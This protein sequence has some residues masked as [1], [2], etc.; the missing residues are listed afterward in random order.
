[1]MR[2][3][4]RF[5]LAA[6]ACALLVAPALAQNPTGTLAGRVTDGSQ[7][8]PGVAVTL[9]SPSLQGTRS[10]VT[11]VGG[12]YI[13]K[14]LPPGDYKVTFALEGFQT[15][16]TNV[17]ITAAQKLPLDAVM[18]LAQV[19][20]ELVVVGSQET[21]STTHQSA[22]TYD[23]DLIQ[24]L[25]VATRTIAG[26]VNLAPGVTNNGPRNGITVSGSQS[27]ENLFLVNGVVV[28]ENLRGQ[29]M[30]LY[31][32]DAVEETTTSLSGVS[33]EY[34]R[35][36][37]GVI[38]TLTKSGGNDFHGSLRDNLAN[39]SWRAPTPLT[40][41]RENKINHTYEATFGGYVLRDRLWFFTAGR[42]FTWDRV[43]Q[44][45]NLLPY[46]YSQKDTRYEGKLTF[47]PV[48]AHR[49]IGSYM[50]RLTKEKNYSFRTTPAEMSTVDPSR[51][52]PYSLLAV[53][54][55]G[56]L[57]DNLFLEGQYSKRTYSFVG[58]GGDAAPGDRVYGT[59][60][61]YWFGT[62]YDAGSPAFCGTCGDEN[63]DNENIVV[64]GSYFHSTDTLGSHDVVF[65]YD[66]FNDMRYNN[67]YQSPSNFHIFLYE[68]DPSYGPNGQL[69]PMIFGYVEMDYW[70]I[71][72][73]SQGTN[74]RTNSL[75]VNDT[76]RIS[77][78]LTANL[79]IR[80]DSNDGK[81]S[82]GKVVASDSRVSPRLGL[83]W[84]V[85]DGWL[86]QGSFGRYVNAVANN[87]AD[88]AG[89][90]VP[91]WFGYQYMG[92]PINAQCDE[93]GANCTFV[94]QYT[95][96]ETIAKM[97][98]WFDSVGGLANTS[99]WYDAPSIRG[100]NEV[101]ENLRSPYADEYTVGLTTKLGDRGMV[102]ADLVHRT[103][104]DFYATR[105]DLTTG[106]VD[107]TVDLAPGVQITQAFD[108]GYVVNE[109]KL[110]SRTYDGLHL[111]FA[112]R[113]TDRF[114]LGGNYTLSRT[115]GNWDGENS[116]SG[117]ITSAI[118][119]YPEYL[120]VRWYAPEGDLSTD[121]RHKLRL[122]AVWTLLSSKRHSLTASLMQNMNTGTPYGALITNVRVS[123]YVT[124]PGY[125]T[126][127]TTNT[128]YFTAR[129]AYRTDT[130][131]STNLS[132]N[133]SF[134]VPLGGNSIEVFVLPEMLNVFN[135]RGV[136]S[137][138]TTV[139]RRSTF[140]PFTDTPTEC[141]QGQADC[142][143]FNWQKGPNFGHAT[144]KES[145][146]QPRTFRISVGVRF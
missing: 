49:L 6:L 4:N 81:D 59:N 48:P 74:F 120:D 2:S 47:S 93:N 92:P 44:T 55:T 144:A 25:P 9:T 116:G 77:D 82:V 118:L 70:P 29:A 3:V 66:T 36:S 85:A 128:Y 1:M 56:A 115:H 112:Y 125:L 24:Q 143:G 91:S 67:N 130:I 97:F 139:F 17:K 102:R 96:F 146:Q 110:L 15:V 107:A 11:E 103:F 38:N 98:E 60:I 132:F 28:N 10:V 63:R 45:Y 65:G 41:S 21:L 104:G 54:Y 53:N 16:D 136:W 109:D 126:P 30:D 108:K 119:T 18:P 69:Y 87:V 40:T 113:W 27:Y 140:N 19:K 133:Y 23:R 141:P 42:S 51:E 138:D 20:E 61:T 39:D 123:P 86:V 145:Y 121:Q 106:T 111:Q 124:N 37:G 34:G 127:P 90:G 78:H 35:F 57:S 99:L 43:D 13:V 101:V 73:L 50:S 94:P 75:F 5:I 135:E 62:L 105:R 95:T 80:Y 31:I 26:I 100:V 89:G 122:W 134:R 142:T 137:P 79:G 52:G 114:N 76:W 22:V 7:P 72:R 129:D 83:S 84:E 131:T 58:S 12:D 71:F 32:E 14:F 8:L 64:K 117:P 33:A 46:T 68:A 88:R